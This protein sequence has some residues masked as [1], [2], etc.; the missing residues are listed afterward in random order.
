MN[1]NI[2]RDWLNALR[3][4]EY[5]QCANALQNDRQCFC[6]LGVLCDLAV[7][8]GAAKWELSPVLGKFC[9]ASVDGETVEEDLLPKFIQQWAGINGSDPYVFIEDRVSPYTLSELNDRLRLD[10]E[11]IAYHIE[12]QL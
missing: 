6:A 12:K 7:K 1:E 10:Y 9:I 8:A 5:A 2:K 3:S 11:G 4:G